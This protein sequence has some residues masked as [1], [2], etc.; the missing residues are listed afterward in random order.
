M[1]KNF[2]VDLNI[3][4]STL[5][6]AVTKHRVSLNDD[7]YIYMVWLEHRLNYIMDINLQ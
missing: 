3:L 4:L 7:I 6:A 2:L 5:V 1:M